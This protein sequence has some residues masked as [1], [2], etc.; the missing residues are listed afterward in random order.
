MFTLKIGAPVGAKDIMVIGIS[1]SVIKFSIRQVRNKL[2]NEA[3]G[4]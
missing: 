3:C 2:M 4:L 1:D